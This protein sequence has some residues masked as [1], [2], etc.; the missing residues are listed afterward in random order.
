MAPAPAGPS[1]SEALLAVV[2]DKTGYP[3][4]M[5]GLDME[6]EADLGID[7]IKRVEILSAV[8]EKV[9]SLPAIPAAELGAMKTLRNILERFGASLDIDTPGA[10]VSTLAMPGAG[11]SQT[12]TAPS[13]DTGSITSAML[14]VVADKTGYPKDMIGLDMEI[15]ADLGIDSIKRVEILSAVQDLLPSLPSIPAAELGA[16]RTLRDILDRFGSSSDVGAPAPH[17]AS[18]SSSSIQ[19]ILLSVVADKT[20]YPKDMIGLDMEI[21][22]DL[23]IDSIKRVEILSAVQEQ[24]PSL[25]SIPAA[26]LGALRTLR[27]ILEKLEGGAERATATATGTAMP[28]DTPTATFTATGT[29]AAAP[30]ARTELGRFVASRRTAPRPGFSPRGLFSGAVLVVRDAHGIGDRL[31][32]ILAERGVKATAVDAVTASTR[33]SAADSARVIDL[34]ALSDAPGV[35]EAIL[36]QKK[37][38]EIA[39]AV[40]RS[41]D[42]ARLFIAVAD[43]FG[44]SPHAQWMGG[45]Q[46]LVRTMALELPEVTCR[47]VSI[48]KGRLD[49]ERLAQA[50]AVEVL[51]GGADLDIAI[52]PGGNR[53]APYFEDAPAL[54]Q[55]A[56]NGAALLEDGSVLLVSGGARGVTAACLEELATAGRYKFAILG[57]TDSDFAPEWA[58]GKTAEAE[59]QGAFIGAEKAA[60]HTPTPAEARSAAQ[61]VTAARETRTTLE[62]L[63]AKGCTALYLPCD[64]KDEG[65]VMMAVQ[66]V[67]GHFKRIDAIVH[68]AG[69]LADKKIAEKTDAQF[70][71]VFDTK[72]AGL[73]HLLAATRDDDLKVLCFFGSVAGRVGNPGQADYAMANETL[74][75]VAQFEARQRRSA[76]VRVLHWG[77][78]DGGMV[79]PSLRAVF[80]ERGVA[81]I[82]VVAGARMFVDAITNPLAPVSVV[83]GGRPDAS[84]LLGHGAARKVAGDLIV[85]SR[86]SPHLA[87]HAVKGVPVF[88]VA[89]ALEAFARIARSTRPDLRLSAIKDLRVLK[90]IRIEDFEGQGTRLEITCEQVSNGSG[91]QLNCELRSPGGPVHYRARAEMTNHSSPHAS[92]HEFE[93]PKTGTPW[94]TEEVYG[95]VLFHGPDF[96]VL[97]GVRSVGPQGG[98]ALVAST[99]DIGWIGGPFATDPAAID[100]GLQMAILMGMRALGRTSLPT[101]VE[102][103]TIHIDE[104]TS[105]P[106]HCSIRSRSVSD[107]KTVS[108]A[109]VRTEDGRLLCELRGIEMHMVDTA[110]KP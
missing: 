103:L 86:T 100:G 8:Q 73:H 10:A 13:M 42:P 4:D 71:S 58:E 12:T 66:S 19:T 50:V 97:K 36:L 1:I 39:R 44:A 53:T 88:P 80:V 62:A 15:E 82:P 2:A 31:A 33:P 102:S 59:L 98:S 68:A 87:S 99:R 25:P 64:L 28:T 81:L 27:Q 57:R 38:F 7:S 93:A 77:P 92:P 105:G 46:G 104:P 96:Q 76:A 23:G 9:P 94:A 90:G 35:R 91:A 14:A 78:W 52:D 47:L 85:S 41:N 67:R 17:A 75:S 29:A 106:L 11:R 37:A 84:V 101:G 69:V 45:L 51:E 24:T 95:P 18:P 22:A 48:T 55:E 32:A 40:A 26:E 43:L 30:A 21:E 110:A 63:R 83:V 61:S 72:V 70:N 49:P 20:G 74:E 5:I 16:M 108:D 54:D 60:G 34:S 3:K 89:L 109:V 56:A 107:L 65:D 6:I 79:T